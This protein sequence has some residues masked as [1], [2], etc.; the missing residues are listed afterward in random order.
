MKNDL[1]RVKVEAPVLGKEVL[2]DFGLVVTLFHFPVGQV[3]VGHPAKGNSRSSCK[4]EQWAILQK[5]TVGHSSI[6]HNGS[7]FNRDKGVILQ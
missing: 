1:Q 4:R 2:D 6:H 7:S 3:T 5:G